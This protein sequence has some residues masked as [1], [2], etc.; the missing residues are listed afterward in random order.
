MKKLLSMVFKLIVASCASNSGVVPIGKEQFF[1]SKQAALFLTL[2]LSLNIYPDERAPAGKCYLAIGYITSKAEVKDFILQNQYDPNAYEIFERSDKKLY[3]T[4]GKIDK[5]LFDTAKQEGVLDDKL[6]CT[7]GKGFNI[8]YNIDSNINLFGGRGSKQKSQKKFIDTADDLKKV[9]EKID[10]ISLVSSYAASEK[11]SP[12]SPLSPLEI[13]EISFGI[14]KSGTILNQSLKEALGDKRYI[15]KKVQDT[16]KWTTPF[17]DYEKYLLNQKRFTTRYTNLKFGIF[18][19]NNY[20]GYLEDLD[21]N[22]FLNPNVKPSVIALRPRELGFIT[23]YKNSLFGT[24]VD[25]KKFLNILNKHDRYKEILDT[26]FDKGITELKVIFPSTEIEVIPFN[27]NIFYE[28]QYSNGRYYADGE[29]TQPNAQQWARCFNPLPTSLKDVLYIFAPKVCMDY[30]DY[31]SK[32]RTW[33]WNDIGKL[34][35][36]K[37]I[38][39]LSEFDAVFNNEL[40]KIRNLSEVYKNNP[41]DTFVT[42]ELGTPHDKVCIVSQGD[43]NADEFIGLHVAYGLSK[44][45]KTKLTEINS[46]KKTY[47]DL[48]SLYI[49]ISQAHNDN[50]GIVAMKLDDFARLIKPMDNAKFKLS[51]NEVINKFFTNINAQAT[52]TLAYDGLTPEKLSIYRSITSM[53]VTPKNSKYFADLENEF[54]RNKI[55]FSRDNFEIYRDFT[56][57][58]YGNTYLLN[59]ISV[60]KFS[61]EFSNKDI[62]LTDSNVQESIEKNFNKEFYHHGVFKSGAVPKGGRMRSEEKNIL[63]IYKDLIVN[64]DMNINEIDSLFNSIELMH[65][66]FLYRDATFEEF[67]GYLVE[68]TDS[69]DESMLKE[70]VNGKLIDNEYSLNSYIKKLS[71]FKRE[72]DAL[73]AK[74]AKEEREREARERSSLQDL[75]GEFEVV[76]GVD[77]YGNV[78]CR[79]LIDRTIRW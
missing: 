31:A 61:K 52:F 63:E 9:L 19:N 10:T 51:N 18:K 6:F 22:K 16:D 64:L 53:E 39:F 44:G 14:S 27:W 8:R 74:K 73:A 40:H 34:E 32:I 45:D 66:G 65:S 75:C 54:S 72:K 46:N 41:E 11:N 70:Y 30:I 68:I 55:M 37:E 5:K 20:A 62:Y 26:G 28:L 3:F 71:I 13:S 57:T 7:S 59:I 2:I 12:L 4:L 36:I 24:S 23:Q 33:E 17:A 35:L 60:L 15:D 77:K 78:K 29:W 38:D 56:N 48:N 69:N 21:G 42:F 76:E 50:C 43:A 67:L 58:F 79:S 1:I 49:E 25:F 47:S